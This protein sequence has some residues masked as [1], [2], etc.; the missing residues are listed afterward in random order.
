MPPIKAYIV[1]DEADAISALSFL[2]G[3]FFA[4]HITLAGSAQTMTKAQKELSLLPVDLLFLDIQLAEGT[5]FQLLKNLRERSFEVIFVTAY[6]AYALEAFRTSAIGYLLKPID[7]QE[8][9][10]AV[11]QGLQRI[12]RQQTTALEPVLSAYQQIMTDK[13]ALPV[14]HGTQYIAKSDILWVE[15]E[16]SYSRL[17]LKEGKALVISKNLKRFETLLAPDGFTRI[18]NSYLVNVRS[19]ERRVGKECRSRWSPYH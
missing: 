13:I 3:D 7:I 2:L 5:G 6:D 11:N 18:H 1:D 9:K 17:K 10:N 14:S 8:V 4:D 15:A 19:E 16:G 12:E